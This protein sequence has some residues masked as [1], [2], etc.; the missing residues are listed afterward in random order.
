VYH[1]GRTVDGASE[2]TLMQLSERYTAAERE[3]DRVKEDEQLTSSTL[4]SESNILSIYE[5]VS[6]MVR[7]NGH[8]S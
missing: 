2:Q 8:P 5:R 3:V 6:I 1:I 4:S 7:R